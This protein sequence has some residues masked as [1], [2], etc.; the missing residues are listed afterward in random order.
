MINF[1]VIWPAMYIHAEKT[2][3]DHIIKSKV[4]FDHLQI[5]SV[6]CASKLAMHQTSVASTSTN[7]VNLSIA[8]SCHSLQSYF[9]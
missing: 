5:Y 2:L 8:W 1:S 9:L 3:P 4:N 6:H 7:L